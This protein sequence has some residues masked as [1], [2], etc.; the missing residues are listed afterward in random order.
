ME[1][2]LQQFHGNHN[3]KNLITEARNILK[4]KTNG[5]RCYFCISSTKL[6]TNPSHV[7]IIIE[8]YRKEFPSSE[9]VSKVPTNP[10]L[11]TGYR[12]TPMPNIPA[13]TPAAKAI[14]P[15]S[16]YKWNVNKWQEQQRQQQANTIFF[17]TLGDQSVCVDPAQC[18]MSL[19]ATAVGGSQ[20]L[21]EPFT[22][23]KQQKKQSIACVDI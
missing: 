9:A 6:G 21:R 12:P 20:M 18:T 2:I 14:Y 16:V 11:I 8:G 5:Q 22:I 15:F 1:E 17:P 10:W 4:G 19:K 23:E 13:A 3:D 7:L